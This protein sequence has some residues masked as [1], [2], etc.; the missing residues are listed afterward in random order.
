MVT[1]RSS[2]LLQALLLSRWP[3]HAGQCPISIILA[4][5]LS[6]HLPLVL[7]EVKLFIYWAMAAMAKKGRRFS[8]S[9]LSGAWSRLHML[10]SCKQE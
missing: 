5:M 10:I 9:Q 1:C 6:K 7:P 3:L 4:L 8:N 2:R